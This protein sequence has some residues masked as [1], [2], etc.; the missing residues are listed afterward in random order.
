MCDYC[1]C[2]LLNPLLYERNF[3]VLN[4]YMIYDGSEKTWAVNKVLAHSCLMGKST[5][6]ISITCVN[7]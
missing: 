7:L 2:F 5:A 1:L 4:L 3:F 6:D